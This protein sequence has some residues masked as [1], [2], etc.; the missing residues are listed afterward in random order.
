M[1]KIVRAT[2]GAGKTTG[3]LEAVYETYKKSFLSSGVYPKILLSTF[4]VKAANELTERLTKKAIEE[5]DSQFLNFVSSGFLEVGTLHS[6]FLKLYENLNAGGAQENKKFISSSVKKKIGRSYFHEVLKEEGLEDSLKELREET[7]VLDFFWHLYSYSYKDILAPRVSLLKSAVQ[8]E[9][10]LYLKALNL[11]SAV[12]ISGLFQSIKLVDLVDIVEAAADAALKKKKPYKDLIKF[13]MN[14][15]NQSEFLELYAKK[16]MRSISLYKKWKVKVDLYFEQ[17]GAFDISDV[18]VKLLNALRS[19]DFTEK[20][21]DFCFFDEYQDTSPIQKDILDLIAKSSV[22]YFV[23]D[24]F[25][26]IY[27]FRGARKGIFLSEFDIIE[28][29][30]GITEY[31]LNNYRSAKGV[32]DFSNGLISHL[33]PDFMKMAAFHENIAGK[34]SVVH[35]EEGALQDELEFVSEKIKKNDYS[36]K[37]AVVLCRS[38]KELL[39]L[40]RLLKSKTVNFKLSLSKGFE[41]SLE[42]IEL[43]NLLRFIVN[44]EDDESFLTLLFS[45][46]VEAE[47]TAIQQAVEKQKDEGLSLWSYF[48]DNDGLKELARLIKNLKIM[49]MSNAVIDFIGESGFLDF[50]DGLDPSGVREKNIVKFLGALIAEEA[51]EDFNV[52]GFC[53]DILKGYYRF[54]SEDLSSEAG[55]TLMT[56]HGSK[57]LQF[58]DVFLISTNKPQ[59]GGGKG[60]YFDLDE[61]YFGLKVKEAESAKYEHSLFIEK[62]IEKEKLETSDERKRLL[63]VAMTRAKQ[64]LTIVGSKKIAKDSKDPSWMSSTIKFL[65]KN[66]QIEFLEVKEPI[67][68]NH[69]TEARADFIERGFLKN[70]ETLSFSEKAFQGVTQNLHEQEGR[71]AVKR[72]LV[73][74]SGAIAEGVLFHELIEKAKSLEDAKRLVPFFYGEAARSTHFEALDYLFSQREFPFDEIFEK[75]FREWGF[76]TSG[77]Q[78]KSGKIDIWA[79]LGDTIWIVDYKTGSI[80]NLEK[81]FEQLFAYKDVLQNFSSEKD[82]SFKTVLVFPYKKKVFIRD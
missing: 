58:D 18:E 36:E 77:E 55:V 53:D 34:V 15:K 9:A 43:S 59:R 65:E 3:L 20:I 73:F 10:C 12:D 25:Q 26:S 61:H 19:S 23:G 41:S 67:S 50:T 69:Q 7:D 66:K 11:E 32:V 64:N 27:F 29:T 78:K 79:H 28:K 45:N 81:G 37:S 62:M 2:A 16:N 4:T 48:K 40:A 74:F 5:K 68:K 31:R 75:G 39:L 80:D 38:V 71:T 76:D 35:F 8:E 47:D 44:I 13:C 24:P 82:L 60:F 52:L 72:D 21:W 33:V 46:W 57:G 54:E 30:G 56:V 70:T 1:N 42:T 22:N 6:V 49:N 63:Y 51:K 14:P 17:L